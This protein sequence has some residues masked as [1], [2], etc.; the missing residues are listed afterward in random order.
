MQAAPIEIERRFLVPKTVID[1]LDID[2]TL[3][4]STI[5]QGYMFH[6]DGR[7]MRIRIEAINAAHSKDPRNEFVINKAYLTYKAPHPDGTKVGA[8]IEIETPCDLDTAELFL[9]ECM[10]NEIAKIRTTVLL[11]DCQQ[12]VEIDYFLNQLQGLVIAEVEFD[13]LE[14][15][16]SFV[17]PALLAGHEITGDKRFSNYALSKINGFDELPDIVQPIVFEESCL[18]LTNPVAAE[19]AFS[20][21]FYDVIK[22]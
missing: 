17:P 13:S 11:K 15:A 3:I 9:Q 1:K 14:E 2:S 4:I 8:C 7:I 21:A 16:S 6:G 5:R 12:A 20:A 18:T 10:A 22:N 19:T